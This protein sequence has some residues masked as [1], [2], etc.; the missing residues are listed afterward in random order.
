MYGHISSFTIHMRTNDI[1]PVAVD[2]SILMHGTMLINAERAAG[3]SSL[4]K[5]R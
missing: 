1:S 3:F 5:E 4:T 2:I